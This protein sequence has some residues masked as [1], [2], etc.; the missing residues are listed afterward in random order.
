MTKSSWGFLSIGLAIGI[1][2]VGLA[3]WVGDLNKILPIGAML[4][5][6]GAYLALGQRAAASRAGRPRD[7]N[8]S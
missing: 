6:V 3:Y 7:V 4:A 8:A 1:V 5:L 2:G